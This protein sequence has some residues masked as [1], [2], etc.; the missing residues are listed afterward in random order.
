MPVVC[1]PYDGAQ[2]GCEQLRWDNAGNT[3]DCHAGSVITART[4]SACNI[5]S[6]GVPAGS[7]MVSPTNTTVS[8]VSTV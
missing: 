5:I 4:I 2:P 8:I 1:L 3:L 7:S 6:M